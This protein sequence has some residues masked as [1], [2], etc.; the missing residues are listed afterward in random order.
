MAKAK[1]LMRPC[2]QC[3]TVYQWRRASGRY[4][5]VCEQCKQADCIICGKKVPLERGNRNTCSDAC[6]ALKIKN[7]QN[8]CYA[9]RIANDPDIN[10]RNHAKQREK[11]LADPEKYQANLEKGRERSKRRIADAAYKQQ[12][13]QYYELYYAENKAEIQEKRAEW[14]SSLSIEER[15]VRQ[16]KNREAQRKSK[17][18]FRNELL[19]DPE[20]LKKYQE[21]QRKKSREY[22]QQKALAELLKQTQEISH[23]ADPDNQDE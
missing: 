13:R 18:K 16:E 10:K 1:I 12:R 5:D 4:F 8:I 2:P 3:G 7:I 14:W 17:Q 15:A 19:K 23:A 6:A 20:K 21:Y 22:Q 11:L 9:K